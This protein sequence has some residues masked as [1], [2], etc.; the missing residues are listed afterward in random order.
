MHEMSM[1]S[2]IML[3]KVLGSAEIL[4]P[5]PGLDPFE[6]TRPTDTPSAYFILRLHHTILRLHFISFAILETL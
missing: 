5:T 3:H 6:D 4:P 2:E 1:D